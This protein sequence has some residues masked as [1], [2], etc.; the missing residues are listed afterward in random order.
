[1]NRGKFVSLTYASH[2]HRSSGRVHGAKEPTCEIVN[3]RTHYNR[4]QSPGAVP[5]LDQGGSS[6]A[7]FGLG[8]VGLA[9]IQ[10][11]DA[12]RAVPREQGFNK[13]FRIEVR[14]LDK[15]VEL[16]TAPR[17]RVFR[18]DAVVRLIDGVI[19]PHIISLYI[20]SLSPVAAAESARLPDEGGGPHLCHRHVPWPKAA[21]NKAVE[22]K[23]HTIQKY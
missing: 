15:E 4:Q 3:P 18:A 12:S 10:G 17:H 5:S 11:R 8:A 20:G 2:R 7:V 16:S 13:G 1:M 19:W 21:S 23:R 22:R 9:V 6:V 14:G